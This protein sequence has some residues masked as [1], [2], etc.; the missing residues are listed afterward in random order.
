MSPL[1]R[2]PR[3]G[4]PGNESAT[5][6]LDRDV[7]VSTHSVA[8]PAPVELPTARTQLFDPPPELA[9]LRAERPLCPLRY[10]D[11]EVGWLVTGYEPARAVLNDPRFSPKG[12]VRRLPIGDPAKLGEFCDVLD[13][14]GV[15]VANLLDLDPPEHTR[16]RKLLAAEFTVRRVQD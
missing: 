9:S 8:D 14:A 13:A 10:P 4:A 5:R 15:Q 12:A 3:P 6:L 2:A 1:A 7:T 11:G 16:I